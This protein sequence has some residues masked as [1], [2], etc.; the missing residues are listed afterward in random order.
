MARSSPFCRQIRFDYAITAAIV[1]PSGPQS[2]GDVNI[3]HFLPS[4]PCEAKG[5]SPAG[6]HGRADGQLD[7]SGG[8]AQGKIISKVGGALLVLIVL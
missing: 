2:G 3:L 6:P 4:S 1:D 7:A 5:W 8:M